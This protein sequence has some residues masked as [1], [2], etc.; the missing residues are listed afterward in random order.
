MLR[1]RNL[2][3]GSSGNAT[4]VE[5]SSGL[6]TSRLLIDCGLGI[7]VLEKRLAL[8]GLAWGDID[9]LFITHEHS[10]HIGCAQQVA[11]RHRIPVWMS[12]GTFQAIGEPDFDGLLNLAHD[13][14]TVALGGF[15][16]RPFTVPHDAR[17]PLQ[18]RCSDGARH[19]GVAT[20]LGHVSGH[21]TA[22]LQGC[23]ALM[24]ESNH[25]PEL[26][27]LSRYPDFLKRRVS[28]RLGHLANHA[29]A[30]LARTLRHPGLGCVV[31]AHLSERNNLPELARAGLA[32]ALEWQPEQIIVADP[33]HG[34]D[35]L[36]V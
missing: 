13:L 28:G 21:V 35:W 18:L 3:S 19:L 36:P 33:R 24:L 8:A 6:S 32:A 20:D 34:T 4:L 22:Q 17:E 27:A 14:Q 23:H 15:E 12:G 7:R 1:F 25:D 5:G 30:E 2:G 10:D 16:F 11:L 31:A 9:A 29:A 26:L